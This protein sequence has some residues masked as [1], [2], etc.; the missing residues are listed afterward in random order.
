MPI[1]DNCPRCA[2]T[3]VNGWCPDA[4]CHP[5]PEPRLVTAPV[6]VC[7]VCLKLVNPSWADHGCAEDVE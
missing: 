5:F 3:R 6:H 7:E 1:V 4:S 2:R